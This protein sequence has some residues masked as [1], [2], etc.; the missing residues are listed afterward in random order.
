MSKY[1][2]AWD[3]FAVD[4]I[5][6]NVAGWTERGST[7][8][9][10][11]APAYG[12]PCFKKRYLALK[13]SSS[14]T[15]MRSALSWDAIDADAN[16]DDVDMV[17]AF[18]YDAA[19]VNQLWLYARGVGGAATAPD[20]CYMGIVDKSTG[21]NNLIIARR[22]AATTI[23]TIATASLTLASGK[24]YFIRFRVNGTALKLRVWDAALGR[25]GEPTTW[26]LETTDATWSAAGWVGL[27]MNNAGVADQVAPFNFFAV[28]TNGD[29]AVC[30]RTNAEYTAWLANQEALRVITARL[31]F[32]GYDSSGSPYTATRYAYISNHGYTSHEQDTP[33]RQHFDN[34]ITAVPT[35]SREMPAALSGQAVV[36]FGEMRVKNPARPVAGAAYLLLDGAS[37]CYA[38]TPDAAVNSIT[39][40]IDIRCQVAMDDW[41]PSGQICLVAKFVQTGNQRAWALAVAAG[42]QLLLYSTPDGTNASLVTGTSTAATGFTNETKHWVRVTLDVNDGGGNRVYRFYTSED[43][44]TWTQLGSTVTTAGVTTIFDSSAAVQISGIDVSA[45]QNFAGKVY[46]AQIYNGIA[47]TLAVDFNLANVIKGATSFSTPTGEVWTVNGT[48]KIRQA[49]GT[50][51]GQ[52][53][54]WLR[55]HWIRDGFEMQ[56][57]APDWPLHDFRHIV[58]GR[59]GLPTAPRPDEMIFRIAD[60]SDALN[61]RVTTDRFTSGDYLDQFKPKLFGACRAIEPPGDRATLV[62]TLNDGALRSNLN[63]PYYDL[64]YDYNGTVLAHIGTAID[65][66]TIASYDAGTDTMTASAAHGLVAGYRVQFAFGSTPPTGLVASTN[67]WVLAAGLTTTAFRLTATQGSTTPV[68][69]SGAATGAAFTGY[70]YTFDISAGTVTLVAQPDGRVIVFFAEDARGDAVQS[71]VTRIVED[72]AFNAAALSL[73]YQ[74][75]PAFTAAQAVD[76]SQTAFGSLWYPAG[77]APPCID[78]LN[79]LCSG[80]RGWWGFTADGLLRTGFIGLPASTAVAA[81]DSSSVK[82]GSLRLVDVI[83]PIDYSKT[84]DSYSPWFLTAGP[85]IDPAWVGGEAVSDGSPQEAAQGKR[86]R[87]PY[88]YGAASTPLDNYPSSSDPVVTGGVDSLL[89]LSAAFNA[90][91]VDVNKYTLGVYEFDTTL[92]AAELNIGD[93]ITL[94]FPRLGWKTYS[95]ADPASPDNTATIDAT[96]AVVIGLNINYSA[97][98]PF[99]VRV[100]CFRRQPGYYPTANLN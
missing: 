58:R 80:S 59:L 40:D 33:A 47:G 37:G 21:T 85:V 4:T 91:Y 36:N 66:L 96:K 19:T 53:D 65:A 94:D 98:G 100:K 1:F 84:L 88:S 11:Q 76:A 49:A 48:A 13:S 67:Y 69:I 78:A 9:N 71:S 45:S 56:M 2:T 77:D 60:M 29:S 95:S 93:T 73:N 86:I 22:N 23:T 44:V 30:P 51:P 20:E 99:K 14:A 74:D 28:G 25:A 90:R 82:V 57:G 89:L 35:F 75:G 41:T 10:S 50:A 16:R 42:G 55:V 79:K 26:N 31:A 83:R 12:T 15:P 18:S 63:A 5:G 81:F 92:P 24:N 68:D 27:G 54:D 8:P 43:G 52:L 61:V 72:I 70:G 7:G 39:G 17:S 34:Y 87:A 46:R 32:T 97:P 64:V 3:N 6:T 38:S 62:Y